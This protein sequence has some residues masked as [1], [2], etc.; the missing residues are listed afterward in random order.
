LFKKLLKALFSI[1]T[2]NTPDLDYFERTRNNT[3]AQV[4]P[5]TID[6]TQLTAKTPSGIT[7]KP[8]NPHD[9]DFHHYLFG[10]SEKQNKIDPF[11]VFVS[12]KIELLLLSPKTLLDQLPVLPSTVTTLMSQIKGDN[13][14]LNE[15]LKIIEQEP[16]IAADVIKTANSAFY[17]RSEKQVTDLKTAFM[18]LGSQGLFESVLIS[19]TKQLSPSSNIYFKQFGEKIW[20]HS[21]RTAIYSKDIYINSN[22]NNDGSTAY[23]VGLIRNLGKMVIF[24][25][26]IEAFSHV[27][28]NVPPNSQAFKN[29]IST[30]ATRLTHSIA[31]HWQLPSEII[32]AIA[33]QTKVKSATCKIAQAVYEANIIS[34][35]EFIFEADII[36]ESEFKL[37]CRQ[38]LTSKGAF[39]L[40]QKTIN[41]LKQA[42]L[43]H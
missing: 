41:D 4:S 10:Q 24:Q 36:D 30:F 20:Q 37:R 28:P 2:K 15:I 27:D 33:K 26:M 14:D 34:E 39:K 19:Y 12:S 32:D 43:T 22:D 7:I 16:S 25:I 17:K 1:K 29:L 38:R 13:F 31:K 3:D 11:S 42:K 23:L 9:G 6:F 18:N 8:I 40:A 35:L 5:Q 21:L